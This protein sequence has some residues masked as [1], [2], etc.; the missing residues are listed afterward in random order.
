MHIH[1]DL[2]H[3]IAI[4]SFL[5]TIHY[6]QT[7]HNKPD[8]MMFIASKTEETRYN[9]QCVCMIS[10]LIYRITQKMLTNRCGL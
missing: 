3:K 1:Y 4:R 2:V 5:L 10:V 8:H 6:T 9:T 7:I